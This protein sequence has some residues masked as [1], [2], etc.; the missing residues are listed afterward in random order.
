M[1]IRLALGAATADVIG[2]VLSDGLK[3]IAIGLAIGAVAAGFATTLLQSQLYD[4]GRLDPVTFAAVPLLFLT[5]GSIA[6]LL[7]AR[8]ATKVDPMIALRAE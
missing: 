4:V 1:G 2:L 3:M 5:V 7:P 8:R 6:C